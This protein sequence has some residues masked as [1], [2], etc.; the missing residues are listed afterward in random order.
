MFPFQNIFAIKSGQ[1]QNETFSSKIIKKLQG[2][3]RFL[4]QRNETKTL[5]P[6]TLYRRRDATAGPRHTHWV[7]DDVR[8]LV[9]EAVVSRDSS[10][11][12]DAPLQDKELWSA[13]DARA[14]TA[15]VDVR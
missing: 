10:I 4:Q 14:T 11:S 8:K 12:I 5:F 6:N 3:I 9:F 15:S 7:V 2:G 1:Q 13:I